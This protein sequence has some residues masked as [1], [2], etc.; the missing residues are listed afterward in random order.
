MKR[1]RLAAVFLLFLLLFGCTRG[2]EMTQPYMDVYQTSTRTPTPPENPRLE[3]VRL[4][5]ESDDTFN[6]YTL[7]SQTNRDLVPLLYDSLV[8]LDENFQPHYY[9]AADVA[10]S[11]TSCRVTLRKDAAFWDGSP[12]TAEDAAYSLGLCLQTDTAGRYSNVASYRVVEDTLE[13][14]LSSPDQYFTQLLTFPV[15]RQGTGAEKLPDGTGRYRMAQE[16][17]LALNSGHFEN[18]S[19]KIRQIQLVPVADN[20]EV[21]YQLMTGKLDYARLDSTASQTQS[22]GGY[23]VPTSNVLYL[24]F[25][26]G[27]YPATDTRFRQAV[28]KLVDREE[29][30]HEAYSGRA[31][32]AFWPIHPL[33]LPQENR[34]RDVEGANAL[35][36][37]M[38]LDTLSEDGYRMWGGRELELQLCINMEAADKRAAAELIASQL[39]EGHLKVTIN[40]YSYTQY[41]EQVA[42]GGYQLYLGE[43][44]LSEDMDISCLLASDGVLHHFLGDTQELYQSYLAFRQGTGDDPS[45]MTAFLTEEPFVPLLFRQDVIVHS[46]NFYPAVVATQLD[47]FYNI[48]MW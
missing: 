36:D 38:G 34:Q 37:E 31:Q 27:I 7:R 43:V 10:L 40:T 48:H 30:V 16:N 3:S 23:P 22:T 25:H 12:L 19:A 47:I 26:N 14:T 2:L 46:R 8:K 33:F 1:I 11:G 32:E 13:I 44:R 21:S 29:L 4:A 39:R 18:A 45:F 17:L 28:D 35:L 42:T 41:L 9:L 5:V 24:G 20:K 6:P 15:I